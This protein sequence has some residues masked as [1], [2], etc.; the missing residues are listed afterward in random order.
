MK[1][2][3]CSITPRIYN[4]KAYYNR[5]HPNLHPQ[6][7]IYLD[8]WEE[9][10]KKAIEG[11][12]ILD[13]P[14]GKSYDPNVA[15]GYRWLTP[16]HYWY[17]NYCFIKAESENR[18]DAFPPNL[19]DIDL[20]VFYD[21]IVC[22]GFS[23]FTEDKEITC[24]RLVKKYQDNLNSVESFT[25][26]EKKL[27][28]D[29]LYNKEILNKKGQIK[30]YKDA[31]EYLFQTFSKPMG[32]AL[33]SNHKKNYMLMTGRGQGKSYDIMGILS[34]RFNFAHTDTHEDWLQVKLGPNI[35]VGSALSSKS[36][37]LL[38]KFKFS[39]DQLADNFG[40]YTDSQTGFSKP[41]FFHK[42]TMGS[43]GSG[44]EKNPYRHQY[45]YKKGNVWIQ[46]GL[47]TALIHGSY[48]NNAE[49]FVGQRSPLM[50]E[51]E[52][53][54]NERLLA[55]AGAD[56]TIMIMNNKIG[57]AIKCGTGGD[58]KK[59][60]EA[61]I[62]FNDPVSYDYYPFPDLYENLSHPIGRFIPSVY[63]DRSF[64]D[65]NGNQDIELA[66]EQEMH[67]R[68]KLADSDNIVALDKYII[69]RPLK[70]SEMFLSP[71]TNIFPTT[72]IREHRADL[73][74][75]E[76]KNHL[77]SEGYL[78]Y[79]TQDRRE[80]KFVPHK[81]RLHKP[82]F[83]YSLKKHNGNLRGS[84][85]VI[86]H[87]VDSIPNPTFKKSLYKI[88]Y[89]PYMNDGDGNS[90]AAIIVYKSIADGDWNQG[91]KNTVVATYYGRHDK[92][93]DVHE[94]AI[95]LAL[96]Y[97]ARILPETNLPD[98]VRYCK[99]HQRINL[100]QLRPNEALDDSLTTSNRKLQIGIKATKSVNLQGEQLIRQ[101]L[102]EEVDTYREYDIEGNVTV[103]R[104][105]LNLH[106]LYDLRLLDELIHYNRTNNTDGVSAFQLLMFWIKQEEQVPIKEKGITDYT[107][108]L[109]SYF[110][111]R[112]QRTSSVFS[113]W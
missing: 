77:F 73:V 53:G 94:I 107:Q 64:E 22:W 105:I 50:V 61:K 24:H 23:G 104:K 57:V 52:V 38:R 43:I 56:N 80:V 82:I 60:S 110:K 106:K 25:P 76:V 2:E 70:S 89:D 3:I 92:V 88:G 87:P 66:L 51:D 113:N 15:G 21:Y 1:T 95:K 59:S 14:S 96:Y 65:E 18:V 99:R 29:L 97:N 45:K 19:R 13:Q 16:Q 109:D 102:L 5:E 68:K 47:R 33:F 11:V 27:W 8:Y 36:G 78:E 48:E 32:R 58:F 103:E 6:T 55:S 83:D 34:Q 72:L 74:A 37:E 4:R 98:F 35:C 40:N 84:V 28:K 90:L 12:F 49:V 112:R 44:N 111:R 9:E 100:L 42:E 91:M 71:E 108:E 79:K 69:N 20:T 41:G 86:E 30:K 17:L 67:E 81:D 7:K 54:L 101:W 31:H 75:R 46:G 63:I 93:E 10:E 62:I 26:K 85:V 39:Q